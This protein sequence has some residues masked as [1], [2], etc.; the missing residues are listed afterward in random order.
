MPNIFTFATS[1][2]STSAFYAWL[3][4][5]LNPKHTSTPETKQVAL[6]FTNYCLGKATIAPLAAVDIKDLQVTTEQQLNKTCRI[7]I[8]AKFTKIDDSL[9]HLFIENKVQA[10]ET[11]KDQLI[12]YD[13]AIKGK[14][15]TGDIA[16][17]YLKS[18][19]D[20]ADPLHCKDIK[21]KVVCKGTF[22]KINWQDLQIIFSPHRGASSDFIRDMASCVEN[23]YN[24]I[25]SQKS[26]S[27]FAD[28]DL[29][30]HVGQSFLLQT[31]FHSCFSSNVPLYTSTVNG[32]TRTHYNNKCYLQVGNSKGKPWTKFVPF[33]GQNILKCRLEELTGGYVLRLG[34]HIPKDDLPTK[35][36]YI[37]AQCNKMH[38]KIDATGLG[39]VKKLTP[40][41]NTS[42]LFFAQISLSTKGSTLSIADLQKLDDVVQ[43]Y[44]VP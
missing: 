41:G 21:G 17:I 25:N 29:N 7:D 19:Y 37:K 12:E 9:I 3:L 43:N 39:F 14:A 35:Q 4:E 13:K 10:N 6:E 26:A 16:E 11:K 34:I 20:F 40:S 8:Y 22:K 33:L 28:F 2:L 31:I 32:R 27:S 18:G 38:D 15:L 23:K 42:A 36:T 30:D 1:E 24:F 5:N 44:V